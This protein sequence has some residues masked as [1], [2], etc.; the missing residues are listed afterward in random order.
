MLANIK[1]I[2]VKIQHKKRLAAEHLIFA[3]T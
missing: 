3:W 2:H 1:F